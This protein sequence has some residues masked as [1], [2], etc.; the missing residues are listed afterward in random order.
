VAL[1]TALFRGRRVRELI[2]GAELWLPAG[3][4]WNQ[5]L[6]PYDVRW[7]TTARA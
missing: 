4:L 1:D 6:M 3:P 2:T 7:L 5:R